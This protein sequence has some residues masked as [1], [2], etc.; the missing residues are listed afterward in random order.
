MLRNYISED[1]QPNAEAIKA[2]MKLRSGYT[3]WKVDHIRF[4]VTSFDV[5]SMFPK[6]ADSIES[7]E[8]GRSFLSQV[9][10]PFYF[11]I[12]EQNGFLYFLTKTRSPHHYCLKI[13]EECK[14]VMGGIHKSECNTGKIDEVCED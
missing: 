13:C 12:V 11:S 3:A 9:A 7:N 1:T 6:G 14:Y 5:R 4:Y 8:A 10:V 2:F